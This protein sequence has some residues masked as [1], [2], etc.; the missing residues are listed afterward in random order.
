[1]VRKEIKCVD[2]EGNER[3]EVHW[4]NLTRA[5]M[6]EFEA[7]YPGGTLETLEF[8]SKEPEKHAGDIIKIFKELIM[9]SY[10]ERTADGRFVKSQQARDAFGAS[11]AYSELFMELTSNEEA[12][13]AFIAGLTPKVPNNP[14]AVAP[15]IG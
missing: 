10:G 11:E 6:I 9:R 4:F 13:G 5:E 12:S 1:M 15:A 8:M 2:F 14:Q 3:T 7:M